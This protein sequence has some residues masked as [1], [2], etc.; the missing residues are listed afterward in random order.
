MRP[1]GRKEPD[2]SGEFR[3]CR[4]TDAGQPGAFSRARLRNPPARFSAERDV[5]H[6]HEGKPDRESYRAD[7]RLLVA[8]RLGN[9]L[10][11]D[12]VNHRPRRERQQV[13]QEAGHKAR[14][15]DCQDGGGRLHDS[16]HAVA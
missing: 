4:G 1:F 10:L 2:G 13:R 15:K 14:Q 11:D 16:E 7:I 12:N 9:E 6:H 5:E 3:D 8:R